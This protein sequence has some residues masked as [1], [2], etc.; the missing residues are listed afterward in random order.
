[1]S[2]RPDPAAASHDRAER[3]LVTV[4]FVDVCGFTALS[5]RL[6]PE[7]VMG[8]LHRLFRRVD[9]I[10]TRYGGTVDKFIGDAAM[11]LFGAPVTHE[12]DPERAVR[13]ALDLLAALPEIQ[14]E[15][16]VTH[17]LRLHAGLS[18]GRVVTGL[19]GAG[20]AARPSALGDAVNVAS[21]LADL[22][23]PGEVLLGPE[24][25]ARVEG[26]V[27]LVALGARTVR[28]RQAPVPV[29]GA[30]R[31]IGAGPAPRGLA[32][33]AFVGRGRELE[34]LERALDGP[35]GGLVAIVG[36]AGVGKSRL[37]REAAAR[38]PGVG[39]ITGRC[40]S[41]GSASPLHLWSDV[42]AGL[43]DDP[44]VA[45]TIDALDAAESPPGTRQRSLAELASGTIG[46]RGERDVLGHRAE[47]TLAL[48]DALTAA[49]PRVVLLDDLHW[50]DPASRE[51]L[52]RLAPLAARL[53]LVFIGV[54]RPEGSP[55]LDADLAS[56]AAAAGAPLVEIPVGPLSPDEAR[57]LLAS[58]LAPATD[59]PTA[60]QE[61]MLQRSE[62]FPLVLEELVALLRQRGALRW[63]EGAWTWRDHECEA[64]WTALPATLHSLL[65]ARVDRLSD[66]DRT[67][68]EVASAVGVRFDPALVEALAGPDPDA[69]DR[70]IA[71]QILARDVERAP[72]ERLRFRRALL[73]EVVYDRLLSTRRRSLHRDIAAWIEAD[74][75]LRARSLHALATHLERSQQ[76]PAAARV[77]VEAAAQARV[78][79]ASREA[80]SLYDRAIAADPSRGPTLTPHRA[81]A[82][83]DVG[84]AVEARAML[85]EALG[86]ARAEG[87]TEVIFDL[88]SASLWNAYMLGEGE[89]V[90]AAA[91]E[92]LALAE[93]L[94]DVNLIARGLRYLGVAWEFLGH[95]PEARDACDRCLAIGEREPNARALAPGIYNS[96]GEISRMEGRY[97]DALVY[98]ERSL[99]TRP[100]DD[101]RGSMALWRLNTGAALV[102]L[103]QHDEALA[104]L[105]EAQLEIERLGVLA[106]AAEAS[107]FRAIALAR[108]GRQDE[109]RREASE[110]LRGAEARRHEEMAALL[111]RLLGLLAPDAPEALDRLQ[112]S[113]TRLKNSGKRAEEAQSRLALAA[114]LDHRGEAAQAQAERTR[115]TALL[116]SCG[117]D[118]RAAR[119]PRTRSAAPLDAMIPEDMG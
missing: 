18:T 64:L 99:A 40:I 107:L 89:R 5:E 112:R 88:L 32:G 3:R 26:R 85:A 67:R 37:V 55:D 22:A 86:R 114:A 110:A 111:D 39:L 80:L 24:T 10:V 104:R 49:A 36:P 34:A 8:M 27:E 105:G 57:A 119:V 65:A 33:G 56:A 116:A 79:G 73:Q 109:A 31:W 66:R 52:A 19:L 61:R 74:P 51:L 16:G 30:R 29:W 98:Y 113:V 28:G 94:N 117:L 102:G 100:A 41:Y 4:L 81:Y 108:T 70:L 11:V 46:A 91:Q 42:A 97:A 54:R 103:G 38:R 101:R 62:G 13:V 96:L 84:R 23:G 17:P 93:G 59:A 118:A 69:W 21:R 15:L 45:H 106:M 44:V 82:M 95:Y 71:A 20:E 53:P 43:L 63:E 12:D 48:R 6:D 9:N 47:L 68:L 75:D 50:S 76:G 25:A 60:A 1:M 92:A 83:G 87:R 2:A 14:R 7:L 90:L 78:I 115:A 77:W 58:L 72:S 35:A